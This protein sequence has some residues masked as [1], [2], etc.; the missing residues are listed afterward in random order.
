MIPPGQPASAAAGRERRVAN[1]ACD[2]LRRRHRRRLGVPVWRGLGN[3]MVIEAAGI[4]YVLTDLTAYWVDA[5][6]AMLFAA[7]SFV[8]VPNLANVTSG[9]VERAKDA[10][11]LPMHDYNTRIVVFGADGEQARGLALELTNGAF[12]NVAYFEGGFDAFMAAVH[13]L[14]LVSPVCSVDPDRHPS[15]EAIAVAC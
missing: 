2:G 11:R 14:E 1:G 15:R 12:H 13:G 8:G 6:D 3:P 5:R 9:E 4:R 7:S 10:R